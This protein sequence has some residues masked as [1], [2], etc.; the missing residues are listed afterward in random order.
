MCAGGLLL[1]TTMC[2]D[3]LVPEGAGALC[4]P[5]AR[6]CYVAALHAKRVGLRAPPPVFVA[7]GAWCL[8]A[9]RVHPGC[10]LARHHVVPSS[11]L[12]RAGDGWGRGATVAAPGPAP[13]REQHGGTLQGAE[14]DKVG[15]E[16]RRAHRHRGLLGST[17]HGFEC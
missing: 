2:I 13:P 3:G 5:G 4:C 6:R 17:P 15:E 12:A 1:V 16:E 7:G 10:A 8:G 14:G 11:M 9:L